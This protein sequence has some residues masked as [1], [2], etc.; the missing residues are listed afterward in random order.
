M[1]REE[2][3]QE[4]GNIVKNTEENASTETSTFYLFWLIKRGPYIQ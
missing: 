2:D 4:K 1:A 3:E